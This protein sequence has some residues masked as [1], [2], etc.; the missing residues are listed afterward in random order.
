[1]IKA[2]LVIGCLSL[3]GLSHAQTF[4]TLS[5]YY[6][7][8][9]DRPITN[10]NT[11]Y[12]NYEQSALGFLSV[13]RLEAHCDTTGSM[14]HNDDLAQR[15]MDAALKMMELDRWDISAASTKIYSERV[16]GNDQNYSHD[17]YRRVDVI[18]KITA[19]TN[20]QRLSMQLNT[21]ASDTAKTTSI[22]LTILFYAGTTKLMTESVP[23]ALV[24][25]EFLLDHPEISA[26]IHGHVCCGDNHPLS[27]NRAKLIAEFLMKQGVQAKRLTFQGHSNKQPKIYPEKTDADRKQ[28]RRVAVVFKKG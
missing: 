4:D 25:K 28:N 12:A 17:I 27:Y 10:R 15:R 3:L 22:D 23:E 16:A 5:I 20:A 19:P 18:V 13:V 26:D 2:F 1:M 9:S 11:E 21:F 6:A 7:L 8:D 14:E 24:L